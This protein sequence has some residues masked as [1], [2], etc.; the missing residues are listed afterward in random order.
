MTIPTQNLTQQSLIDSLALMDQYPN[1]IQHNP[2]LAKQLTQWSMKTYHQMKQQRNRMERIWYL[3]LAFFRGKQNIA[4]INTPVSSNGFRLLTPPAPPWRVRLVINLI[5]PTVRREIAKMTSQRPSFS[6]V[7]ATNED[8]DYY[9]ARAAEQILESA[10]E[11]YKI[12]QIN[13]S[14]SW[15]LSICGT[16]FFKCYWNEKKKV[17]GRGQRDETGQPTDAQGD[18]CVENIIPFHIFVPDLM[19]QDIECQPYVFH[20]YTKSRTWIEQYYG[21]EIASKATVKATDGDLLEDSFFDVSGI[22]QPVEDQYLCIEGW[23]KPGGHR[24]LPNGGM[25]T[26]VGD[27]LIQIQEQYPYSHG[28]YPFVK[29]DHIP[30]GQFY[31]HS[32][33]EDLIAPQREYNRTRSQIIEAK[34]TMSKPKLVYE[35]G[36]VDPNKITSEPGQGIPY[37]PG[38]NPPTPLPLINLPTYVGEELVR[39]RT[40]MDDISGQHEISRGNT[41]P[42]VTAATAISYLQEQDDSMIGPTLNSVEWGFQKLGKLILCYVVDYWQEDRLIKVAGKNESFDALYFKGNSLRGNTDVR[43]Q[44]GS[45]L[46]SSKAARQAFLMDLFKMGVFAQN[47]SEFLRILD[48]RGIDK[49]IE[50]YQV[51]ISQAQRENT[52]MKNGM[53]VTVNDFDNHELHLDEHGKFSKTQ[54]YEMLDDQMKQLFIAHRQAHQQ[55]MMVNMAFAA[56]QNSLMGAP[57]GQ[58]NPQQQQQSPMPQDKMQQLAQQMQQGGGNG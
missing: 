44:A 8:E 31:A 34:N 21:R 56:R 25:F 26:I 9:A 22:K 12:G 39:L 55:A 18:I 51:D 7:P 35:K 23:V 19:E 50:S 47:P 43:V 46:A 1:S 16:S 52:K 20:V 49:V 15:W 10:Y 3:N 6:V 14:R 37:E 40:D 4:F 32:T 13:L 42:Q 5:R 27:Q 45:A 38:R 29:F 36:S 24:L 30:S 33:I 58:E 54:E 57:M 48:L 53:E 11:D 28:E 41:P 17:P 2:E